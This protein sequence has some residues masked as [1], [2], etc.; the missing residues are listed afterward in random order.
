MNADYWLERRKSDQSLP[1]QVAIQ[2]TCPISAQGA[3]GITA[4]VS[5]EA[6]QSRNRSFGL[7]DIPSAAWRDTVWPIVRATSDLL[8][9]AARLAVHARNANYP[10]QRTRHRSGYAGLGVFRLLDL[11][12][13]IIAQAGRGS[14]E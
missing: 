14:K 9:P 6:N 8:F 13:A 10:H 4:I 1:I 11:P 3:T 7:N 12:S 5:F 2:S